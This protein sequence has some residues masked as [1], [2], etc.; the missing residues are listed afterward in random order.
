MHFFVIQHPFV[1]E[2]DLLVILWDY[3]G[4]IICSVPA[5]L[6]LALIVDKVKQA[7]AVPERKK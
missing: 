3:F 1:S 4:D 5:V 7:G 2:I 6:L